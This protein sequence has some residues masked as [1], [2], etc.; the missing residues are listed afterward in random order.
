MNQFC[1]D[2]TNIEYCSDKSVRLVTDYELSQPHY[3]RGLRATAR[4]L[5][6]SP[7]EWIEHVS[8]I[9]RDFDGCVIDEYGNSVIL[10]LEPLEI[11]HAREW[12]RD[13]VFMPIAEGV[14]P[15]L[16]AESKER[17]RIL[18]TV[19]KMVFPREALGW[20]AAN[21]NHPLGNR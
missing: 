8:N 6:Y 18:G 7:S 21:D 2:C 20:L 11:P 5:G 4:S 19:L 14:S 12:F 3:I 1:N 17:L 15:R 9:Y 13:V 10:D 16:R